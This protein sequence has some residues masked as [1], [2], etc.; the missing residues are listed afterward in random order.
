M[1]A[2]LRWLCTVIILHY[3]CFSYNKSV[4]KYHSETGEDYDDVAFIEETIDYN[5]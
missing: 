3:L 5:E 1:L 2:L 4:V